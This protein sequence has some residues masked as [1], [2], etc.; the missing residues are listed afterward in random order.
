MQEVVAQEKAPSIKKNYIY[1]AIA[2]IFALLIPIIITPY[3]A[4]ILEPDGTGSISFVAS[5]VS[6][7]VILAN[8]GIE[9]YGQKLISENRNNPSF[10]KRFL[11]E[12]TSLRAI[13]TLI[14]LLVYFITF[15][16]ILESNSILYAIHGISLLAVAVDFT[17]FFQGVE[18][19]KKIAF[20]NIL[21]KIAYI[22]FIFL[23]VKT[24]ADIN[25]A[26]L[27]IVVST[28]LPY[29]L[30]T[31]FLFKF[32]HKIKIDDKIKPFRHF[33]ECMVYFIPTIAIQIYTILDKTM[34]GVITKSEAQNGFYEKAEQIAK[35]PLTIITTMNVIMRSRI[36]YYYAQNEM[37]KIT[38]LTKKSACFT[39][40]FAIPILFGIIIVTK[41]FVPIYLGDLYDEC[42]PLIYILSPLIF[43]IAI[44]NLLGTHYYTPFDKQKTSNKFLII[45]A[46]VNLALNSV[47][48]Y[49][50]QARGAAI[51]SVVAEIV[52]TTLYLIFAREFFSIKDF[53][54]AGYKY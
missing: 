33:K 18:D 47:L 19:F 9:T 31:P 53:I 5:N 14:C 11:I 44:S 4:R 28:V 37:D 22:A 52:V 45:G 24:K 42:I 25:I 36:S 7:F 21:S 49:F 38:K 26:A 17:W 13:L 2:K 27:I 34:I 46:F 12:I 6:Y 54:K 10:L 40:L 35:L 51:A 23:F 30:L 3:L 50:F 41:R 32:T 39:L 16:V 15:V 29:F 1:N 48:I 8:L 43:I 20:V